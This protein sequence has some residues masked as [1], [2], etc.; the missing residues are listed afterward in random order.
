MESDIY[1]IQRRV[2]T[3]A[4]NRQ[5][6]LG[7]DAAGKHP[8]PTRGG[9]AMLILMALASFAVAIALPALIIEV[10]HSIDGLNV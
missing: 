9:L 7:G 6:T 4:N 8:S 1:T 10:I 5:P 2:R 3:S